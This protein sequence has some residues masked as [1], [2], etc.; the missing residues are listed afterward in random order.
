MNTELSMIVEDSNKELHTLKTTWV[1]W[2]RK[3]TAS[4]REW[5]INTY[6]V[7]YEFN[8]IEG[9]WLFF[10]SL[11][12][13]VSFNFFIMKKGILPVYECPENEKGGE[14]TFSESNKRL[15]RTFEELT[16]NLIADNIHKESEKINGFTLSMKRGNTI[17]KIWFNDRDNMPSEKG[18]LFRRNTVHYRVRFHNNY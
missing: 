16:V 4:P 5:G 3:I 2:K 12:Q 10:K 8:T 14:F 18:F 17:F 9:F 15:F 13:T 7:V 6:E 1:I 11:K